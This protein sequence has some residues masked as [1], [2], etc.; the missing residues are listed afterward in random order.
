MSGIRPAYVVEARYVEG[1]AE[2]R[3]PYRQDHL[4][5]IGKLQRERVVVAAGAFADMSASLM[6]FDLEHEES[7]RAIVESDVYWRNGI[8]TDYTIRKLSR[9]VFDE[10]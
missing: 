5:R 4:E 8:W 10:S 7:V 6:V 3:A 2:K 1:A 9:V